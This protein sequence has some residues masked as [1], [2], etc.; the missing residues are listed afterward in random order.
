MSH[1]LSRIFH[2]IGW[3]VAVMAM[4][5]PLLT[6]AGVCHFRC[7]GTPTS[8]AAQ[9]GDSNVSCSASNVATTC[10]AAA[11]NDFCR[12]RNASGATYAC[13]SSGGSSCNEAPSPAAS[14]SSGSGQRPPAEPQTQATV[15][16]PSIFPIRLGMAIGSKSSVGGINEYIAAG[17]GYALQIVLVAAIIMVIYG[18]FR[19]VV[20][21]A[22]EDV[23]R[24]KEIVKDAVIGTMILLGA[25]LIL[26]TVNPATLRL[27]VPVIGGISQEAY[28]A[29]PAI[30]GGLPSCARDA[31]CPAGQQCLERN[32]RRACLT[33]IGGTAPIACTTDAECSLA[34]RCSGGRCTRT[35]GARCT[36]NAECGNGYV[37]GTAQHECQP[38][39]RACTRE[40]DC[41]DRFVCSGRQ[42]AWSGVSRSTPVG[43]A[44]CTTN[45]DCPAGQ[46]CVRRGTLSACLPSASS[47]P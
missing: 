46:I 45:A 24:G 22:L 43:G 42:C 37:C 41:P 2:F 8:A 1:F 4:M 15:A 35:V 16:R 28:K 7:Q 26:Y 12:G 14:P 38:L 17:Y 29:T 32:G 36:S 34:E 40:T 30:N 9:E 6:F 21:S 20:G 5:T 23:S 31:D 33:P 47:A 44:S 39:A 18:G 13:A 27:H 11:C 3:L 25:Y 19:Y 10:T